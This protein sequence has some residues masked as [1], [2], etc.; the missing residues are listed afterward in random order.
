MGGLAHPVHA[1]PIDDRVEALRE[2]AVRIARQ[3]WD[4]AELGYLETRSS[5]LLQSKLAAAGFRIEKEIA[6]IPTAFVASA[7]YGEPVLALLAEFDALPGISQTRRPEQETRSESSSS[8]ACGHNLFAGGSVAAAI[9]IAAQLEAEGRNGTIRLYGTPAEEGGSGKVYLVRAGLFSDVDAALHWH[10][11]DRTDAGPISN[12]ANK[13]A[14]FR[15]HGIASHAALA[16]ERGRSALDGVEAM[17][18][19]VNLLREHVPEDTRIHYVITEGGAAPNVVPNFAEVFYYVRHPEPETLAKL[20]ERVTAAA[21]G[22]ALGTGTTVD[23]E[24]IHGNYSLLPNETLSRR[25]YHHAKEVGAA[26]WDAEAQRFAAALGKTTGAR[27]PNREGRIEPYAMSIR[28]SS[29]DVGDVSWIVPTA[30]IWV[31]TWPHGTASHSWQAAAASGAPIGEAG[32]LIAA[33]I[34]ARTA[35]D[36]FRNPELVTQAR[37]E[38]DAAR[39]SQFR[40]VP[41]LGDRDPPFDYRR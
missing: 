9:A 16:P 30:G 26:R 10:P 41:L 15:F 23:M 39:G 22:A 20:W 18:H 3:I 21:D 37:R 2:P 13:S 14:K 8:H 1:D 36:I 35:L 34:V 40:Y 4:W 11:A 31:A 38:F 17:N 33:R 32:M 27:D 12:L 7:G 28:K 25:M 6:G 19:M 5:A 24:I 29:T